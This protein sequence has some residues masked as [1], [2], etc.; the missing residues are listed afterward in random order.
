MKAIKYLMIG[1]LMT[2]FSANTM[3]QTDNSAIINNIT[4]VI[5]SKPADLKDQVKQVFKK[6]KKNPEVIV[7]IAR[8]F[9]EVKDTASAREYAELAL[10]A[11]KKYAPAYVL[12][13]DIMVLGD[14]GGKAAEQ[15]QQAIYFAP[16][17]PEAYKKYAN[18]YRKISPTEAVSKLEELRQYRPD[19]AIDAMKGRIYYSE[20]LFDKA[21]EEYAKADREKMENDDLRDYAMALFFKQKNKESLEI[22]KYALTKDPRSAAF[23]R[24]AMFN[25]TDLKDY[26]TALAYADALLNK[27]DSEKLS[28]FDYT[29]YGNALMGAKQHDKALEMYQKALTM[30]IENKDKRAGVI[31]TISDAY[32]SLENYPEAIKYYEQYLQ[33]YSTPTATDYAG[34]AQLYYF[35]ASKMTGD[36]MIASLKKS[37]ELYGQLAEKYADAIE[38]ATFWRARV[39]NAMDNDQQNGYA[40]PFYEKLIELYSVRTQLTNSDKS[41]LKESYLYLISYEA[42]IANNM[43]AAKANAEKLIVIDPENA[44]AKQVLE[45]K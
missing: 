24:L 29:Y 12:L 19:L 23:N 45:L 16:S 40:K 21:I 33:E 8:A 27:S 10:K 5:K 11:D 20:N 26:E 17:E 14:E 34:L 44:V 42:R 7:G 32:S 3:A 37:D 39:N 41:R 35:Q 28:Y 22:A 9:Y 31:K 1:A 25:S 38:F 15:Y 6:N 13:G 4:S 2:G 36:E 43:E 30:D 18:I